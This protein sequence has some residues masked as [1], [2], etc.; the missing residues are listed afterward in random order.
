MGW[1]LALGEYTRPAYANTAD[2]TEVY[3][4]VSRKASPDMTLIPSEVDR[5]GFGDLISDC[6]G[7]ACSIW[8]LKEKLS[9]IIGNLEKDDGSRTVEHYET[10]I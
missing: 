8:M 3:D 9:E 6:L 10:Y 2:V 7:D 1:L 4:A 5:E